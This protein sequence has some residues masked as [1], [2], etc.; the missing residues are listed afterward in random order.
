MLA[1][2]TTVPVTIIGAFAAMFALDFAIN[3][4]T[5]FSLVFEIGIVVDEA[6][7][8]VENAS[9]HIG[10]GLMPK[11]ASIASPRILSASKSA[12]TTVTW[13]PGPLAYRSV[14]FF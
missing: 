8:V 9:R 5:L 13:R 10:A 7:V 3:L 14:S 2:A 1:P 6:I 11:D 4:I 12:I